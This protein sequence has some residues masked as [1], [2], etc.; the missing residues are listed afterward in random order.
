M[1]H[2][3]VNPN[4]HKKKA[5]K[6]LKIL[7]ERLANENIEHEIHQTSYK[8]EA[9]DIARKLSDEGECSIVAIGGD[10][11]L[12]DVLN[13]IEKIENVTLGL[14]PAGTGNDFA[15]SAKIPEDANKAIDI[16]LR[17][18]SAVTD[19]IAVGGKKSMNA[20]GMGIDVEVLKRTDSGKFIKGK[21][22]YLLSLIQ[23]VFCYKG[24]EVEVELNGEKT[25]KKVL[26]ACVCNGRRI[27]GGMIISPVAE[28]DD[29]KLDLVIVDY[30]RFPKLMKVFVLLMQ[31]KL[32]NFPKCSHTYCESVKITSSNENS[33]QLDGE[34]YEGLE[35]DAEIKSGLKFFRE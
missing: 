5:A 9:S 33:C 12:H 22:K 7:R 29:K 16:I 32:L 27:G 4:S 23:S 2:F 1:I 21:I 13:G 34:R 6:V 30:V 35:F 11:M 25:R 19:Y 8:G 14:I 17:G 3:I 24:T 28:I 18:N 15:A 20:A 31:G 26:F 10:G